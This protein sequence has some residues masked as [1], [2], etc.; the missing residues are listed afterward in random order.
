MTLGSQSFKAAMTDPA[1]LKL[2]ARLELVGKV[3]MSQLDTLEIMSAEIDALKVEV[4]T[5]SEI[6]EKLA[7]AVSEMM[8]RGK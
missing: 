4:G 8:A 5:L 2:E 1:I 7:D 3:V 6:A